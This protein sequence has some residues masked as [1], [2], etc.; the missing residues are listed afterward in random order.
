MTADSNSRPH[1]PEGQTAN[2]LYSGVQTPR[3]PLSSSLS[4]TEYTINPSPPNETTKQKAQS[5]VPDA[6]LL[7]NG[8]PDVR[9]IHCYP[10]EDKIGGAF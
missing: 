1:T 3:T 9:I 6:F 2:G 8:F 4:L 5:A 10:L 7:P